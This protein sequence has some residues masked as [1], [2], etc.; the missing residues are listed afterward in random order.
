M[1]LKGFEQRRVRR[2]VR[3]ADVVFRLD[4][5]TNEEVLPIAIDERRSA[6]QRTPIGE[7]W[8][9]LARELSQQREVVALDTE[10]QEI[11]AV[12]P[13][14]APLLLLTISTNLQAAYA[15]VQRLAERQP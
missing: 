3:V 5:T 2:R 13:A 12:P 1:F 15:R 14:E 6:Q 10:L 7:R 8:R 4:Q 9:V 11:A